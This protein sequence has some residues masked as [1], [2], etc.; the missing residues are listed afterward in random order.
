LAIKRPPSILLSTS[1]G[2][3]RVWIVRGRENSDLVPNALS[4]GIVYLH[5]GGWILGS[6]H[7]HDR[8]IRQLADC[9]GAI[10]FFIEYER[11]PEVQW[12]QQIEQMYQ[13]TQYILRHSQ[14]FGIDVARM[15]IVGDSVGGNMVPVI[16]LMMS[17][18]DGF[19][20]AAQ[21]LLYPVTDARFDT[22]SYR[23]FQNGPW[24]T[25]EAMRWFWTAYLPDVQQRSQWS[26][27]PLHFS[28]AQLRH[29]PI[30]FVMT[31]EYDVLRDEG[32]AFARKLAAAGVPVIGRRYLG[33]IHDCLMLNGLADAPVV[34][35]A[36][37]DVCTFLNDILN[38]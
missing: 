31:N 8:L 11:A 9:A 36:L 38:G 22:R 15:A 20:F 7:T 2:P 17:E 24:L 29:L 10:L 14:K 6:E 19:G 16:A 1:A 34:K 28:R 33:A 32:E 37:C 4:P 12:T 13:V 23:L 25:R 21:T 35:Q 30:T 27:S 26:A 18:L 3:V 5:G